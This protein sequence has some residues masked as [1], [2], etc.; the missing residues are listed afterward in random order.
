ME[1]TLGD[2]AGDRVLHCGPTDTGPRRDCVNVQ[3][4]A[5]MLSRFVGHDTERRE[6]AR[7]ELAS[8]LRR[9]WS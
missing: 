5:A 9:H 8:K 3:P 4:A 7:G 1:Q 2:G 6:L